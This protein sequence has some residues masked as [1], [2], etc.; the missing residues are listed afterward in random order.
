M[1]R[2]LIAT[3]LFILFLVNTMYWVKGLREEMQMVD[4]IVQIMELMEQRKAVE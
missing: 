4:R 2:K 3:I 1:I